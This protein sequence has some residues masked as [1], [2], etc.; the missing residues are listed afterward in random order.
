MKL[1]D[2]AVE[3]AAREAFW[4]DD[5]AGHI[6]GHWTWET[7]PQIGRDEYRRLVRATITAYLTALEGKS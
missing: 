1:D 2:E 6:K 3:T 4:S 5:T 7:I